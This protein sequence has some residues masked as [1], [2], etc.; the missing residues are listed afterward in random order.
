[1]Q[2]AFILGNPRSGTSLLRLLLN[3]HPL[4]VAPPE[5]GFLHWWYEKYKNWNIT[6]SESLKSINQYIDDLLKSK[7]IETWK[8]SRQNLIEKIRK[9][10]PNSYAELSSLV[11]QSWNPQHGTISEVIIDKNNYYIHYLEDLKKIWSDAKFI[12]LVRDGRDVACS[13]L[14]IEKL[15]TNS[16]YKPKLPQNIKAIAEEWTNNNLN[17]HNFLQTIPAKNHVTIKYEDLIMN[18]PETIENIL[19]LFQLDFDNRILSYYK[20]NNEPNSTLDWKKKTLEKI[21]STN[22]NKFEKILSEEEIMGFQEIAQEVLLKFNYKI[23]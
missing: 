3:A 4:V 19:D 23:Y 17:I 18:P 11:Y 22:S 20:N 1:M 10:R 14:A 15:N 5:S 9:N 6:H 16:P 13:Y 8:L 2:K 21:D 7:K 12:F